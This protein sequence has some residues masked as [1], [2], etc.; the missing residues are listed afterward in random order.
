[1][2]GGSG[3]DAPS[4]RSVTGSPASR[5]PL[6]SCSRSA[7]PGLRIERGRPVV[8]A[9]HAEQRPHLVDCLPAGD[10]DHLQRVPHVRLLAVQ[11]P[12]RGPGLEHD[13][14][15]VVRHHVVQ[16][17]GDPAPLDRH[18]GLRLQLPLLGELAVRRFQRHVLAP[19]AADGAPDGPRGHQPD[20][21]RDDV[22][23]VLAVQPRRDEDRHRR[24]HQHRRRPQRPPSLS[25]AA[26]RVRGQRQ[27]DERLE[28]RPVRY[29]GVDARA[30]REEHD[31]EGGQRP[32]SPPGNRH[33]GQQPQRHPQ[34]LGPAPGRIA[35]GHDR[36]HRSER[37]DGR[38]QRVP[39]ALHPGVT[40]QVLHA[41]PHVNDG[42]ADRPRRTSAG[43]GKRISP[44][45]PS[46]LRH[47]GRRRARP[48]APSVRAHVTHPHGGTRHEPAHGRASNYE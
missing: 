31:R 1:M 35:E 18:R 2:V 5:T 14:R 36:Q 6:R 39:G 23:G 8:G 32:P 45:R 25:A 24:H 4:T 16:L 41:A 17:A 47:R 46:E 19:P 34:R 38:E 3:R 7:R 21:G 12:G 9:E 33:R 40:Q 30:V 37:K 43:R 15:H 22:A 27:R 10:R 20:E 44:A 42:T 29:R 28:R 13:H 11:H 48:A 26:D